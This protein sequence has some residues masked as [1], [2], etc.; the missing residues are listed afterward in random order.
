[1]TTI[2]DVKSIRQRPIYLVFRIEVGNRRMADP[3]SSNTF[4]D[5]WRGIISAPIDMSLYYL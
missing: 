2:I 4:I 3:P 5:D 1:M